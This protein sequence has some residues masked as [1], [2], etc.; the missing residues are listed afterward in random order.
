MAQCQHKGL[1]DAGKVEQIMSQR[2]HKADLFDSATSSDRNPVANILG[3][4]MALLCA[5]SRLFSIFTC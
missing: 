2:L 3:A 4:G 1:L 5:L